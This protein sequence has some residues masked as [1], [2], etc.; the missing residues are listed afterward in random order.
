MVGNTCQASEEGTTNVE[1]ALIARVVG[2]K[3]LLKWG[4]SQSI[5]CL[6]RVK[7]AESVKV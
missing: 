2:T 1:C 5:L 4:E 3:Q 7:V 6:S